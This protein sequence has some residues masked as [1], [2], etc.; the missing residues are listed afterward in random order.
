MAAI[1]GAMNDLTAMFTGDLGSHSRENL[2]K[3][4]EKLE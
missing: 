4:K 1:F 3:K 2:K